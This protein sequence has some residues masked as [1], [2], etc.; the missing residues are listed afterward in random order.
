MSRR[1]YYEQRAL[2]TRER[3]LECEP[4]LRRFEAVAGMIP[5][6]AASLCDIGTGN[7]A[8]LRFLEDR[9]ATIPLAGLERSQAAVD[10]ALCRAPI[11]LGSAEQLPFAD[12]EFDLCSALEVLEHLPRGVYEQALRE[13]ERVARRYILVSV[14]YNE[15]RNNVRCPYCSCEFHPFHHM[16]SFTKATMAGLFQR[17]TLVRLQT[18]NAP[19]LADT[20]ALSLARNVVDLCTRRR[21]RE[22]P[23][24]SVCPLCGFHRAVTGERLRVRPAIARALTRL[25]KVEK[26]VPAWIVG[27]YSRKGELPRD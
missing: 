21:S 18:V 3:F 25:A 6:D 1:E 10:C 2:W 24:G 8:F 16:R 9:G 15:R 23:E 17:F 14:P 22:M 20:L 27:L 19:E 7:G 26:R 5:D 4:E 12:R 11:R 13:L